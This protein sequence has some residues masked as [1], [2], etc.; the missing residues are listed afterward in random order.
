V[1]VAQAR[2]PAAPAHA[3]DAVSN[4][5]F[6]Q[7]LA[8]ERTRPPATEATT[9]QAAASA[10]TLDYAPGA[11]DEP[12]ASHLQ[13]AH[14]TGNDTLAEM[15]VGLHTSDYGHVE[16]KTTLQNSAVGATIAVEHAALREQIV[17]ALPELRHSFSERQITLDSLTVNDS[18]SATASFTNS[19]QQRSNQQPAA[20]PYQGSQERPAEPDWEA[21]SG[22]LSGPVL[23]PW[24][25]NSG[26]ELNVL[27]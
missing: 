11:S 14:L 26:S 21:K 27:V 25:G 10:T 9:Q 7:A 6:T 24:G 4:S 20:V 18:L 3:S 15:Q 5:S 23:Q 22:G 17:S 1:E 16:I 19:H 12:S 8:A 2:P 13:S